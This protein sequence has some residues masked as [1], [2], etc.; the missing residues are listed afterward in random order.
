M[1]KNARAEGLYWGE[2]AYRKPEEIGKDF[3][4]LGKLF[5]EK[6][7]RPFI[8]KIF[9]LNNASQALKELADRKN[10]VKIILKC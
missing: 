7:L 6:K 5:E 4:V 10:F 1:L 2:L 9:D 3:E 8:N